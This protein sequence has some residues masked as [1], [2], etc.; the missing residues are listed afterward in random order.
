MRVRFDSLRIWIFLAVFATAMVPVKAQ[1]A[2]AP[3]A[4]DAKTT[5]PLTDVKELVKSIALYPDVLVAQIL[6]AST[7]PLDIVQAYRWMQANPDKAKDEKAIAAQTWDES[8]KALVAFPDILKKMND[9]LDWTEALGTAF[10]DQPDDVFGAIQD[11]RAVAKDNGVLKDSE[12]QKVVVENNNNIEIAPAN[13]QVVY[14]PQYDPEVVYVPQ[15]MPAPETQVVYADSGYYN[16]G[17]YPAGGLLAFGAGVAVGAWLDNDCDWDNHH[18]D[19]DCDDIDFDWDKWDNHHW[20][21]DNNFINTGDI[22][23]GNDVNIGDKNNFINNIDRDNT[24]NSIQKNKMKDSFNKLPADRQNK[25][26]G[27]YKRM[28]QGQRNQIGNA[29]RKDGQRPSTLPANTR[30]GAG[31]AGTAGRPS[32]L[33]AG[34]GGNKT[35]QHDASKAGSVANKSG[36]LSNYRGY[37]GAGASASTRLPSAG[38]TVGGAGA[39][40]V[41]RQPSSADIQNRLQGK[42]TGPMQGPSAGGQRP[43]SADVQNR[44]QGGGASAAQRPSSSQVQNRLQGAGSTA[45][46]NVGNRGGY[47][48]AS[49]PSSSNSAFNNYGSAASTRQASNR[50][51]TSR[52][53]SSPSRSSS[54]SRPSSVS[55]PSGGSSRPSGGGVSRGGGGGASRGGG[56]G[57]GRGGRR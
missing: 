28:D 18:I 43:S 54:S 8:V 29:V 7:Y 37:Q 41:A 20:G 45:S 39:A 4:A 22:N 44:L 12:Q 53:V 6:P 13:P 30:P 26:V 17:Y 47:S 52:N 57:G 27:D 49:R 36:Q 33:P 15:Y 48:S 1:T 9:Q 24:L 40:G 35:W 10:L 16:S 56:G 32:T 42:S 21:G 19:I 11:L 14:V 50:G 2:A 38:G 25:I 23:I 46:S 34:Q 31:G 3:A 5:L 55:R 51:A